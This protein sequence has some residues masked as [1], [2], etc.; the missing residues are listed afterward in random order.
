MARGVIVAAVALLL[1]LGVYPTPLVQLA[2]RATTSPTVLPSTDG[3][4]GNSQRLQTASQIDPANPSRH[5]D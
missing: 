4:R 2:R 1:A 3:P 5:V